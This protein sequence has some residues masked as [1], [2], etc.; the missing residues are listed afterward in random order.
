MHEMPRA[1]PSF[2]IY[3]WE[4]KGLDNIIKKQLWELL[5][6]GCLHFKATD[7]FSHGVRRVEHSACAF[8]AF[9]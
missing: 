2:F 8:T 5:F 6:R 1:M 7:V 3:Y 4:V 9:Q